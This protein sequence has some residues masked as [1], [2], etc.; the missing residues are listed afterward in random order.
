M[1]RETIAG[2]QFLHK[3]LQITRGRFPAYIDIYPFFFGFVPGFIII[4]LKVVVAM[5]MKLPKASSSVFLESVRERE[6]GQRQLFV[7]SRHF[8]RAAQFGF[9]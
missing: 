5:E 2:P 8:I 1:C 4:A 7:A 9:Y 3:A 6:S